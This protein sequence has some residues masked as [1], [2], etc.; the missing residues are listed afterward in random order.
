MRSRLWPVPAAGVVAAVIA[1]VAVPEL[2][3]NVDEGLPP[4]LARYLFGGGADA[5]RETLGVIA[6]SL[7]TVTSL[8]FSLTLVTLQLA[9]S[10]YTPRLLRTFAAD[11]LIQRTLAL[12]L[13]TFAYA[14]TVLRTVRNAGAAGEEFVPRIAI[15]V[16]YLLAMASVLGLVLFLGHLVRQIRIETMLAHVAAETSGTAQRLLEQVD[17]GAGYPTA[18]AVPSPPSNC[19]VI[20]AR[21]TG[22]LVEVD[23]Q[24]L[25]AAAVDA[26]AVVWVGRAVGSTLVSGVPVGVCW[27]DGPQPLEERRLKTLRERVAGALHCGDRAHRNA[28]HRIRLAAANGRR[29]SGVVARHQRP[30]HRGTRITFVHR[31][32]QRACRLPTRTQS[33]ARRT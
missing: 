33:F 16:A 3:A 30:H 11:R 22:F 4:T 18:D 12:F 15:T 5:A 7:I 29:G 1:G 24:A 32:A 28:R 19:S 9:S 21:S 2:D 17:P 14:L 23:E 27:S 25:L 26:N 13:A 10:Q 31:G 6:T 8:T 20:E